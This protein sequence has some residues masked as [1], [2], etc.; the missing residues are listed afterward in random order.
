MGG[1]NKW[2]HEDTGG[3]SVTLKHSHESKHSQEGSA[4][5]PSVGSELTSS[6]TNEYRASYDTGNDGRSSKIQQTESPDADRSSLLPTYRISASSHDSHPEFEIR[7][8]KDSSRDAKNDIW[9]MYPN[10]KVDKDARFESKGNEN[11]ETKEIEHYPENKSE[12]RTDQEVYSRDNNQP[13]WKESKEQYR[14]KGT[15]KTLVET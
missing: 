6:I 13:S 5:H 14:G 7:E 1:T 3:H 11:K 10:A 2:L 8:S 15:L 12:M 9:G 4:S